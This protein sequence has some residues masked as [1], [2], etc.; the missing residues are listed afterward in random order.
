LNRIVWRLAFLAAL[1]LTSATVGAAAPA[2]PY[3]WRN[4]VVGGGGFAPNLIFSPAEKGLAYLRTD[5]GGAYRWD[6]KLQRWIPLQ[7]A[8]GES[9]YFGIESLAPDPKDPN[10]VYLAAGMYFHDPAAILRSSDR[11]AT[12]QVT[13]VPFRMGGNEDGRGLGERLAIDP[14]RTSTL[15]F[16]SRHD[17]LWRSDDSGK[18]WRKL[19]SFPWPGLG[20]PADWHSHGGVSFVVFDRS[21][22]NVFAGVADPAKQHLFRSTDGG[23]T[24]AAVPGGPAANLLPVKAAIDASGTLYLDYC[25]GIGPNG[26]AEGA[27]WKLDTR[28]NKWTDITPVGRTDAEGG[29]MGLSLDPQRPGRVAVSSVDRWQHHDSVWVSDD[30]GHNW[31]SLRELSTR[32]VS[33]APYLKFG[34]AEAPFGHWISGLA[35]D[36]FD[37]GTIAYTTGGTV[38]RTADG[39]KS[40]LLW[41]P[42]VKGI[43][44]TVPLGLASPTGGA[45]LISAIGDVHGFVHDRL[46]VSPSQAFLN[47]DLPNTNQVDYAGGAPNIL[48]RSASFYEPVPSGTSLAW[49]DDGGRSWREL[50]APPVSVGSESPARVDTN[51]EVPIA[52][53]ADG[54]TFVVSGPIL[55][56]T[57]DRGRNWWKPRGLP[58]NVR[59]FADKVSAD[60]WYAVDYSGGAIFIS[61]DGA[62]SFKRVPAKGLPADISDVRPR[63]REMQSFMVAR[64]GTAGELWFMTGWRLYRST[65]F[66]QSFK[67]MTS[68]DWAFGLYGLGKAAP[69]ATFPTLYALGVKP[70]FG[71]IWRSIDGGATWLRINDGD[72]QMGL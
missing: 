5:V 71:G 41:K 26:I 8:L 42:W 22:R 55:L 23:E 19:V 1:M 6:A 69:G 38:Y 9:N 48:V 60:L 50:Q 63:S 47:P 59:A 32:D 39:L 29:F 45:H 25:T 14:N 53:S 27:V 46:D 44:E 35:F 51:G 36:P 66:A 43:E 7:D 72:H 30:S 4:V 57:S 40:K 70:T 56:A 64:P 33:T 52:V 49:S 31:T 12:W 34:Q 37:G 20:L 58:L 18:N 17:G 28:A 54:R 11:G 67:A 13:P 65:N 24:F 2:T 62:H 15:L 16:G 3:V 68:P 21:S 61:R 10:V